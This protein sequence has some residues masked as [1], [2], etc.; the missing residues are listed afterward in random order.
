VTLLNVSTGGN[1]AGFAANVK[2]CAQH[3]LVDDDSKLVGTEEVS[4]KPA[5]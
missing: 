1:D 2:V 3:P 4:A 5:R